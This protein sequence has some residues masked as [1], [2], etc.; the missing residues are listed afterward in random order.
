[1][2]Q[3][4]ITALQFLTR[5]PIRSRIPYTELQFGRSVKFFPLAGG[6]I[7]GMLAAAAYG[8][9]LAGGV[10]I[11]MQAALLI[12]LEV[13]LTGG[14]HCDGYMDTWDGFMS[15]SSREGTLAIMKDSRVGAYGVMALGLLLL[16]K[17]SLLLAI[18]PE[19]LP[20]ALWAAPVIARLA[21]VA[22][23]VSYPYARSQGLGKP[24]SQYA[25]RYTLPTAGVF[26][27]VLLFAA[28]WQGL[29]AAVAGLAGAGVFANYAA[30]RLGG[31]TGDV[32]GAIIEMT[33]A[34]ALTV[35][36]FH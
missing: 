3:D 21:V 17:Y 23:I 24:F 22:A 27:A 31:L 2:L 33:E 34:T 18:L 28:G 6:V 8:L 7:G 14:L 15:A 12:V 9:G 11:H 13:M 1:M 29:V 20:A 16:W 36:L 30:N 4:V 5:L 35:F 25:G 19:L 32:Y 26:T 10:G